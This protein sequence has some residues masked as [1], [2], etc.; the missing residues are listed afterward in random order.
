MSCHH[1]PSRGL[2]PEPKKSSCLSWPGPILGW[3]SVKECTSQLKGRQRTEWLRH[4]PPKRKFI[5]NLR[6][7]E[8]LKQPS[9]CTFSSNSPNR[10]YSPYMF[11]WCHFILWPSPNIYLKQVPVVKNTKNYQLKPWPYKLLY[12][13]EQT[14]FIYIQM[15][16]V[17]LVLYKLSKCKNTL[18]ITHHVHAAH[19]GLSLAHKVG[20]RSWVTPLPSQGFV[21]K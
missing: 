12:I 14:I 18:L 11:T 20:L 8:H 13:H 3:T 1:W 7:V 6:F 21:D 5:R 2:T 10:S 9:V 15:V 4:D 16:K 19:L 17:Y